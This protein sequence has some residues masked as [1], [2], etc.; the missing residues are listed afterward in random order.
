MLNKHRVDEGG[1]RK[2]NEKSKEEIKE[3]KRDS[4]E[5]GDYDPQYYVVDETEEEIYG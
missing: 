1:D 2:M 3:K 5:L 4:G